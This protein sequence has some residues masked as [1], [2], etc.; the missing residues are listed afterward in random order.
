MH[1]NAKTERGFV[2]VPAY[3]TASP[4]LF[5]HR[6]LRA[7]GSLGKDWAITHAATGL[8]LG[9]HVETRAVAKAWAAAVA[10]LDWGFES[11]DE[12]PAEEFKYYGKRCHDARQE[13]IDTIE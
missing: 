3:R 13:A 12:L 10:D 5:V 11:A 7:D 4:H 6:S 9:R 1:I 8:K 2:T